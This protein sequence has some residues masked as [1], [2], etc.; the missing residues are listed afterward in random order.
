MEKSNVKKIDLNELYGGYWEFFD[1]FEDYGGELAIKPLREHLEELVDTDWEY[2]KKNQ[3]HIKNILNGVEDLEVGDGC[4]I[5][6]GNGCLIL[7]NNGDEHYE[8][9]KF[10]PISKI[11]GRRETW[12]RREGVKPH[13]TWYQIE[14]EEKEL[15]NLPF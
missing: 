3:E 8:K 15:E 7:N 2:I 13:K 5:S 14:A 10:E 12:A 4:I 11:K 1:E 6:L 9:V